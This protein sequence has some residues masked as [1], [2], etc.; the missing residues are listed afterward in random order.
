MQNIWGARILLVEDNAI[1]QQVAQETMEE[2]GIVVEIAN[3]GRKAVSMLSDKSAFDGVLMDVQMP[4]MDGY[5]ATQLIRKNPRYSKLPII[6]MTAHAM[7]GDRERCLAAGMND[8]VAKPIVDQLFTVLG[9]WIKATTPAIPKKD[10]GAKDETLPDKLPG[11]DIDSA[12]KR[13]GGNRKLFKKLLKEFD[14][15]YQNVA[16][17]I[18]AALVQ[19]DLE[20]ALRLSHTLKGVAGNLSAYQLQDAVCQLENALMQARCDEHLMNRVEISLAQLLQSI[21]NLAQED[22]T[23]TEEI[24]ATPLDISVVTPLLIELTKLIKKNSA[25]AEDSLAT[26][27]VAMKGGR[28][29]EELKQL[30][31]CL[32][33]FDFNGAQISLEAIACG[34][35]IQLK[36]P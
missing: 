19:K 36:Y 2:A 24:S 31:K 8:Y 13:L 17:D 22:K 11:I 26:L 18:R 5:Q 35:G 1:N 30:E 29:V 27:K 6:A 21:Q 3:N 12:L 9:K 23:E 20:T 14:Q 4:E 32:N 25:N 15:D 10:K 7:I 33:I 28:F 16:T 34:L